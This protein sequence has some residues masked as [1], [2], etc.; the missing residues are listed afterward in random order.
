[1]EQSDFLKLVKWYPWLFL[2]FVISFLVLY[3][4]FSL[5]YPIYIPEPGISLYISPKTSLKTIASKLEE[6]GI[7]RS[8]FYLRMYAVLTNRHLNIKAGDYKFSGI[9]NVPRVLEILE[10]GGRGIIITFP[11]GLTLI[12]IN[13]ILNSK[14]I[15]V[16]LTKFKLKDFQNLELIKYFTPESNLEGFLAPDTYEF[17]KEESEEEIVYKFLKNFEKKFL[18]EFLKYPEKNFYE[19]LIIASILEKE[20]KFFEDMKIIAGI[21]DNRLK[22]KKRLEVDATIAYTK[23]KKY[24]CSWKV[25]PKDLRIIDS[26]YNTYKYPGVPPTPI[27]NPGINAI[28]ASLEPIST[29][30]LYY[31]TDKSGKAIFSKSLKEHTLNIK[32]YLKD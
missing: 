24:P 27:S 31:L 30:Y 26:P 8:A 22:N 7:I 18:Q 20:A 15:K 10:K 23:C 9:L 5:Y 1:M 11:E 16:D 29:D 2:S 13:D 21:L 14:G 12:E 3:S 28:K 25:T 32:K 19:R 4:L 17:F 6:E